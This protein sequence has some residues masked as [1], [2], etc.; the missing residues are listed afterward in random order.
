[1]VSKHVQSA[2]G[3]RKQETR[4]AS[5]QRRAL[6]REKQKAKLNKAAPRSIGVISLSSSQ[7]PRQFIRQVIEHGGVDTL[8][9]PGET[10]WE[11]VFVRDRGHRQAIYQLK[12][13]DGGNVMGAMD[14]VKLV[15][16][17]VFLISG[18]DGADDTSLSLLST[19]KIQGIPTCLGVV[20]ELDGMKKTDRKEALVALRTFFTYSTASRDSD[21]M[22]VDPQ[23][24]ADI[25]AFMRRI[26]DSGLKQ[27]I[28]WVRATGHVWAEA[29]AATEDGGVVLQ[30]YTRG[31]GIH[32][33]R[34][35]HITGVGDVVI[36]R[37]EVLQRSIQK[38]GSVMDTVVRTIAR[39]ADGDVLEVEAEKEEEEAPMTAEQEPEMVTHDVLAP[40]GTS[41]YQAAW[42]DQMNAMAPADL[43]GLGD[44]NDSD[45]S[46]SSD[47]EDMPMDDGEDSDGALGDAGLPEETPEEA[48]N[49]KRQMAHEVRDAVD[50]DRQYPDEIDTPTDVPARKR[51]AKFVS[52]RSL[53]SS[54]WPMKYTPEEYSTVHTY[55]DFRQTM[56]DAIKRYEA[57][58]APGTGATEGDLVRIF[59]QPDPARPDLLADLPA[60]STSY[61]IDGVSVE[62]P[63]V[64]VSLR[65]H[66]CRK[67]VLHARVSR[68]GA[69]RAPIP[70]KEPMIAHVGWRR[71][72]ISPAYYE[73]PNGTW[74]ANQRKFS[75]F[76][77]RAEPSPNPAAPAVKEL[78]YGAVFYGPTTFPHCPVA[79]FRA[80]AYSGPAPQPVARG[81][82]TA[83][84]PGCAILKRVVLTGYPYR[85]KKNKAVVRFMFFGPEDIRYFK[86]VELDTRHGLHGHITASL[87]THGY[88]K[89]LFSRNIHMTDTVSMK[90]W[91]RVFPKELLED[92]DEDVEEEEME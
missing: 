39:T 71:L 78:D 66:E 79:M 33:N 8:R 65:T 45:M 14:L 58:T 13:I 75:R 51:F 55:P 9:A 92:D 17:V 26:R 18:R 91:K 27:A 76:L 56:A 3:R 20:T 63:V 40:Q 25:I 43:L 37:V 90:L 2:A 21:V 60:R 88:F 11:P 46:D 48:A 5:N 84:D 22:E 70:A 64:F 36:D 31:R 28:A 16:I 59:V 47:D 34:V 19:L 1:M 42:F 24:P 12:A 35:G 29:V 81:S 32:P 80:S 83:C 49:M 72:P 44:G 77:H 6:L 38:D 30:G 73:V 57:D 86:P 41:A 15:D 87:G 61:T 54:V 62:D 68:L 4:N 85:V 52:L 7:D 69:D 50:D 89:A 10:G 23:T 74:S 82:I 53:R 67:T